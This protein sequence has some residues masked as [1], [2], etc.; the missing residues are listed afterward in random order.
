MSRRSIFR[1]LWGVLSQGVLLALLALA[2]RAP[3]SPYL[4]NLRAGDEHAARA[5]R[6][7]AVAAYQAAAAT[8]LGDPQPYLRM[9]DV[10]L[11]WGRYADALTMANQ[12]LELGGPAVEVEQV[13]V[14]AYRVNCDWPAVAD[15]AKRLV[16][17][18]PGN[19]AAQIDLAEA[20]VC[21]GDWQAARLGL[22]RL[23]ARDPNDAVAAER[24]GSLLLG[25]DTPAAIAHLYLAQT[26]LALELLTVFTA[27]EALH[28]PAYA[29][30]LVGRTLL[31][32]EE[33][34]LAALHF[35][36]ALTA[37]PAYTEAQ[38]YLGY[39]LQRSGQEQQG[40]R[41]LHGAVA[42]APDLPVPHLLLGLALDRSGDLRAARVAY[43]AAY[44]LQPENAAVCVEI[45]E[46]W[47][48]EREYLAAELWLRQAVVLEPDDPTL[49][50]PLV[51]FYVESGDVQQAQMA[52]EELV[53]L[54][55]T[56]ARAHDLLGWAAFRGGDVGLA[57][58]HLQRAVALDP[59]DAAAH[60]H[61]GLLWQEQGA[62]SRAQRSFERAFDL[63]VTGEITPLIERATGRKWLTGLEAAL[64]LD[65]K[66][67]G[68]R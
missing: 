46:S 40:L 54:A 53:R 43:E 47:A 18:A 48:V 16:A 23:L 32:H 31:A 58:E 4:S 63:D 39:A 17:L 68:S 24:L 50:E 52:A 21:Q 59:N 9:A 12:A 41:L 56:S 10:A 2:L 36:R 20:Q 35:G 29:S 49:W 38:A 27:T 42:A 60:Y 11:D 51:R 28:E 65:S 1:W 57:E 3:E 7:A 14:A 62:P 34:C 30:A 64:F 67:T 33:W 5:E 45:G 8:R 22:E 55:P 66:S 6:A 19:R 15:H 13:L 61:L 25:N 44:D 26:P 37:A